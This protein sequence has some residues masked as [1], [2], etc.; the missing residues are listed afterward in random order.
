VPP[1]DP[2]VGNQIECDEGSAADYSCEN[3]DLVSFIP[4]RDIEAARGVRLNDVW[5]WT[6]PDTGR[7]YAL[8]GTMEETVFLD[9]ADPEHPLYLGKL[10]KTVGSRGNTWRDMKTYNNYA[11]IVAD[12]AGQH[13][14]QVF[15]LTRLRNVENPP[16]LFEES[17]HYDGIASSHNIVINEDTGF[18]YAVGNSSGGESCGGALHMIDIKDPLHP[19]FAGCFNDSRTGSGGSGATHDAQCV[20]Y[21][22]PDREHQG[23]EVCVGLNGTAI[24][25][26]DVSDKANPVPISF[27]G[28]PTSA[29]VHQ[30]WLTDDHRYFYQNDEA[31]ELSG[32][33]DR[34]RTLVWDLADLDD[35]ILVTEFFGPTNATD[36]NL[37]IDGDFMYET[38]NASGLRIVDISDRENPVEFGFFDTT[39]YG[40]D[41]AGFNGT[42]SSYPFFESGM[43]VVTSRREGVFIVKK[44]ERDL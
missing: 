34:T 16:V 26:A 4:N 8:I 13:G 39:P 22:G 42:W 28:Y 24:S 41:V 25:V 12:G 30:G 11:F 20:V 5:G 19:Q 23:K 37:Y 3:V 40:K 14:M 18:A 35:P 15:D 1:L 10:P 9:L 36:H 17:A 33:V 44:R 27:R 32:K 2:I 43:I 6:D 7:E 29:Y 31:D 21:H 38:N